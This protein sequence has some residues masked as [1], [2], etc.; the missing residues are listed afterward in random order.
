MKKLILSILAI[1]VLTLAVSACSKPA[2][3]ELDKNAAAEKIMTDI[4]F[5][6]SLNQLDESNV[7]N[8]Y[9]KLTDVSEDFTIYISGTGLTTEE[10]AIV[11]AKEPSLVNEVKA[12]LEKRVED[13]KF[14]YE[15]YL[16]QQVAKLDSAIIKTKGDW[17]IMVIC[18]DSSKADSVINEILK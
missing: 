16:P 17:A 13:Q 7:S 3:A 14:R 10:I 15:S 5:E 4:S 11:K 18:E 9:T 6:D 12:Q 1:S 8:Y 2:G